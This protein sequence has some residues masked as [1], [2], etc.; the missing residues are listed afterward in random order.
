MAYVSE[1]NVPETSEHQTIYS[2]PGRDVRAED[3]KEEKTTAGVLTGGA[4]LEAIGG[5]G[6]VV[7]AII[8]LANTLPFYLTA[9]ACICVGGA[10]VSQGSAMAA[11]WRDTVRFGGTAQEAEMGGGIAVETLGGACGVVLGIIA[12]AHIHPTFLLPIAA[13]V[14]GGT[15]LLGSPAQVEL[16]DLR[17]ERDRKYA[18]VSREAVKATSGMLGMAGLAGCVLGILSLVGVVSRTSIVL[19]TISMLVFGGALVLSGGALAVK[20]GRR[21]AH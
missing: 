3:A 4:S 10:L 13:I 20:F 7:L 16:A 2:A 15:L 17:T 9:I 8:A 6:A 5:G 14:L 19:S 11:R 12:L 18:K 1:N 21:L